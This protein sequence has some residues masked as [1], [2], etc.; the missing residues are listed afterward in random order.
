M[1]LRL[2]TVWWKAI[3]ALLALIFPASV[4]RAQAP[5]VNFA[6]SER[7]VVAGE[8]F[9]LDIEV[10]NGKD[11]GNPVLPVVDG[12]AFTVL[13]GRTSMSETRITNGRSEQRL[14]TTVTVQAIAKIPGKL[15]VPPVAITVD[16][17]EWRSEPAALIVRDAQVA[18]DVAPL[19][20]DIVADPTTPFVGQPTTLTLRI[21]ARPYRDVRQNVK[22]DEGSMWQFIDLEHSKFGL[23]KKSLEEMSRRNQRPAGRTQLKGDYEYFVYPI[24]LDYRASRPGPPQ[25]GEIEIQFNYPTGLRVTRDVFDRKRMQATGVRPISVQPSLVDAAVRALPA[26][27]Q[28]PFFNGAVGRFVVSASAKPTQIAVGDPITVT[29]TVSSQISDEGASLEELQAPAFASM[30]ELNK[31][32]RIPSDAI[33]GKISDRRKVFTQT[34]RPVT[35]AVT[36]IPAIP[37]AYFDAVS[38][39]YEVVETK[40]IPITVSA[41]EQLNLSQIV[42]GTANAVE[43]PERNLTAV[44]G[45]LLANAPPSAALLANERAPIGLTLAVIAG[46]PPIACAAIA[47][48]LG[49]KRRRDADPLRRRSAKA[50]RL[51]ASALPAHTSPE[52]VLAALTGYVADRCGL[53]DG[54]RTRADAVGAL[55]ERGVDDELV[56]RF[57]RLLATCER[58]RFAPKGDDSVSVDEARE[59]V[60]QLEREQLSLKAGVR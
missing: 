19:F 37:F 59:L 16:G 6:W 32:F 25:V 42:G 45:G 43:R 23:F 54:E 24:P 47:V 30:P 4:A 58:S 3:V 35:D 44:A 36:E 12:L 55:R 8:R 18:D 49:A 28:P 7:E 17:K 14:T 2:C 15:T 31:N 56:T 27:G 20:V 11:I 38:G 33:A 21:W 46:A 26:E 34:F 13:P 9:T 22:L 53:A 10:V 52:Q 57:D 40:A 39:R 51:A 48:A 60:R 5:A 50:G 29:F 1:R 41:A